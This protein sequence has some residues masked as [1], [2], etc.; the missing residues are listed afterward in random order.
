MRGAGAA[1]WLALNRPYP[2][3][4][5]ALLY[6]ESPTYI[7]SSKA[8]HRVAALLAAHF[9]LQLVQDSPRLLCGLLPPNE[10]KV[11]ALR[12]IMGRPV[13][14]DPATRLHFIDDR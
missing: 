4:S 6:C 2:G 12:L 9:S 5:D 14:A 8:A 7:V 1:A 10:K 13:C 3:A 11:E